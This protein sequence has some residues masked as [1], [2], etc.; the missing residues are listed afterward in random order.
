MHDILQLAEIHPVVRACARTSALV[1]FRVLAD[2][3]ALDVFNVFALNETDSGKILS[4]VKDGTPRVFNLGV[5]P[6]N[7][8]RR[9][10]MAVAAY[11]SS[12]ARTRNLA[13]ATTT[14]TLVGPLYHFA[15]F[16][17]SRRRLFHL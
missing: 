14:T 8:N 12:A 11:R 3:Y 10:E 13:V 15:T 9:P 16:P 17:R 7:G 4:A 5:A 2:V 1:V 6:S